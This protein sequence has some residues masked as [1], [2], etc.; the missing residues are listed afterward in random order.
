MLVL[1]LAALT[2]IGARWARL[3]RAGGGAAALTRRDLAVGVALAA[4]WLAV[5]GL[6]AAYYRVPG[7]STLTVTATTS[8]LWA[9]SRCSVPGSWRASRAW[10]GYRAGRARPRQ[11][12][13]SR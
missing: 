12:S 13:S 10:P 7:G 11:R 9:R 3:Q 5:W 8:Q 1:G 4:S 2:W 6:H